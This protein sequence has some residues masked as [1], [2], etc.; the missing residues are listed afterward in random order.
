MLDLSPFPYTR[1]RTR[2]VGG[3][4]GTLARFAYA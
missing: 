1:M 3:G 4:L 2:N